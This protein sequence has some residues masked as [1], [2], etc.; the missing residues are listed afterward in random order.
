[1]SLAVQ[2]ADSFK[3]DYE[4]QFGW[5]VEKAGDALAW[6]FQAALDATL[7]RLARQPDLGRLRRFRHP[8]LQGLRSSPVAH[9]FNRLLIFYRI[10][11]EALQA[12]RLIH[13]SRDLP[14]RLVES[15]EAPGF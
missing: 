15:P 10:R 4:R 8:N 6:R 7:L 2:K 13:G 1:M 12:W 9:P 3:A 14:R 11:G 5:Y